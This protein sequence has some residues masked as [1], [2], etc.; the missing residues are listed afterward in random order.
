MPPLFVHRNA[1]PRFSPTTTDPSAETPLAELSKP[2]D[3]PKKPMPRPWKDAAW[4]AAADAPIET[5]S[6]RNVRI[7][8][9]TTPPS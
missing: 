4:L 3:G 9:R 8:F 2:G 7:D 1:S 6:P 5:T